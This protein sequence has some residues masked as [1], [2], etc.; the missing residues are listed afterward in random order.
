MKAR[1]AV[2]FIVAACPTVIASEV[3]ATI[4]RED[5]KVMSSEAFLD[6]HPDI[7]FRTEGWLAYDAGRYD[8]AWA[9]FHHAA[10]YA[11][12]LSQAMLAE[13]LWNGRG[14][15]IDRVK[16][17]AWA[18]LAA[19]RGY[20]QFVVLRERYWAGLTPQERK[21]AVAE[22][23]TLLAT[24]GDA[25]AREHMADHLRRAR[26][27]MLSGRPRRDALIVIPGENGSLEISGQDF[28]AAKFWEPARYEAWVDAR[29][30]PLP[31]GKVDVRDLEVVR[32]GEGAGTEAVED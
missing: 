30:A 31:G 27:Y 19:E 9:H 21:R 12:K 25:V 3:D 8:D 18:D 11:D 1:F 23:S 32:D 6:A 26:R 28:Y 15:P 13:M 10:S 24:Y 7:K 4:D 22:G 16:A 2:V 5:Q 29:W 14:T 20:V 17:Y